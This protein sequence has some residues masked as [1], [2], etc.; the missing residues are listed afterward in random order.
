MAPLAWRSTLTMVAY[1]MM[2]GTE[3]VVGPAGL[4]GGEGLAES[5]DGQ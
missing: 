4:A 1:T 2:A 3:I 5:A